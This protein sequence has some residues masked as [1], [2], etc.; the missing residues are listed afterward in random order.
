MKILLTGD[1]GYDSIG[2]QLLINLLKKDHQLTIVATKEQQSGT[3]GGV[4]LQEKTWG[5][6]EVNGIKAFWVDGKPAEAMEFA[7]GYFGSNS[8]DLIIS[9][10]NWGEN[11]GY[12]INSS[13]TFGA[14][15]RGIATNIA[16]HALIISW[17][18]QK[19]DWYAKEKSNSDMSKLLIYPGGM[20]KQ[21]IELCI[22]KNCW[23]KE[24][25]NI[26]L[27]FN[28]TDKIKITKLQK[29]ITK[30]YK[31]PVEIDK[32]KH[33]YK[34][35]EQDY[36]NIDFSKADLEIDTNALMA[37]YISVTPIAIS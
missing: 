14:A 29:D 28:P 32:E 1:D 35:P 18:T 5:E 12:V 4:S 2:I 36:I 34:Y 37:G 23:E 9:G 31:F 27:P 6:T 19:A 15:F 10:L 7:Q 25:V 24:F 21:I 11:I 26:N 20:I 13:G 33:T 16:P 8:F 3:G 30:Y 22:E 17:V